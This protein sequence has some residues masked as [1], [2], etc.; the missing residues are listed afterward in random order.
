LGIGALFIWRAHLGRAPRW[1]WV[2]ALLGLVVFDLFTTN[3]YTAT[4][5]PSDPFPALSLTAPITAGN[6]LPAGMKTLGAYRINNHYGLPLNAACVNGLAEISGG[7]PIILRDYKTFLSRVPED[8]YSQLLN[9][10]Y[11]VTWRGG[12]GTD[13]GRRIPDRKVATDKYQNIEANTFF[14][15]W[16]T[17]HPQ[18][19]WVAETI[20]YARTDDEVYGRMSEDSY[21]PMS[22][23]RWHLKGQRRWKERRPAI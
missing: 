10:W 17:P 3:R 13:N 9:V 22:E 14:L 2:T 12:M 15:N 5:P 1:M 8:V 4:Q 6:D 23:A 20:T 21:R 11:T 16:P 19:A 18:P 7:S